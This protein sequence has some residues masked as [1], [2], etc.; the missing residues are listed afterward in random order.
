MDS[1]TNKVMFK[2]DYLIVIAI[3]LLIFGNLAFSSLMLVDYTPSAVNDL[4]KNLE[5]NN[6]T[7]VL[8]L[9][10][11]F[12]LISVYL[13]FWSFVA[14]L[15]MLILMLVSYFYI[16]KLCF[17]L[18][19]G[20]LFSILFALVFFFNP[21]VYSRIMVGQFGVLYS[22]LLMPV[23]VYY[24]F[25]FF[26]SKFNIVSIIKMVFA[27]T[28]ASTF[29]IH[30][31]A[32][33]FILFIV[34]SFWFYYYDKFSLKKFA[35]AF[36]L[37]AVFAVLI[38]LFWLQGIF[39]NPIFS[40]I[41]AQHESFFSPKFSEDVPAV[42]KIMGMYGF[43][44]EVGYNVLYKSVNV[45]VWYLLVLILVVLML[46]GYYSNNKDKVSRFFYSLFWIG[47]ILGTGISHPYTS[48]IFDFF[49]KNIPFFN[50][51]RDS[52]KFVSLI[53][54][55]YAYLVPLGLIRIK[56]YFADKFNGKDAKK[57]VAFVFILLF[58]QFAL[59]Y[60]SP[61]IFLGGQIKSVSYPNSYF[62]VGNYL[63]TQN[64]RGYA[65][66]LP[67][68]LYMTYSWTYGSSSDGRIAVPVNRISGQMIITGIDRYSSSSGLINQ[69]SSCLRSKDVKCLENSGVE[70]VLKDRCAYFPDNYSWLESNISP[71]YK[72][73]CIDVYKLNNKVD[74]INPEMPYRFIL[75][76]SISILSALLLVLAVIYYRKSNREQKSILQYTSKKPNLN[77]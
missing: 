15:S 58:L 10:E 69:I 42:S 37:F 68:Q 49:F 57:L 52:H 59:F 51:F 6:Y 16:K 9:F 19:K 56:D 41:D 30:F 54:L 64:S 18:D 39:S 77:K 35:F 55:S 34:A 65:I 17:K 23:F 26:E 53:A 73:S 13:N 14:Q 47:L 76:L 8:N 5:M 21:F 74:A 31:F 7:G 32:L 40:V 75:G 61:M 3:W 46:V 2:L 33:N 67:W 20:L 72:T 1:K 63:D 29:S 11:L 12:K 36:V 24:L 43:W 60:N 62:S 70:Y 22:Y 28:I 38:N 45:A 4:T 71:V 66:Y 27:L 44:R 25:A 50:G 48:P